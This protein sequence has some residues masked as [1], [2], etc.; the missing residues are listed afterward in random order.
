MN[1]TLGDMLRVVNGLPKVKKDVRLTVFGKEITSMVVTKDD[2]DGWYVD[3]R[4][5]ETNDQNL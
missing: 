5:E 4:T 2:D 3:M 1:L